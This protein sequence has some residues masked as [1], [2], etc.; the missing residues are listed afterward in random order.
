[1]KW[2]WGE[3]KERKYIFNKGNGYCRLYE[4]KGE[5]RIARLFKS[6]VK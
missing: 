4:K 1:M 3:E 5:N 6:L 2:S